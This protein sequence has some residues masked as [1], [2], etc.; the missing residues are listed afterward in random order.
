MGGPIA[1]TFPSDRAAVN[2]FN[3][4]ELLVPAAVLP[5]AASTTPRPAGLGPAQRERQAADSSPG[6]GP[7]LTGVKATMSTR[8]ERP[9]TVD[10]RRRT[11]RKQERI[12]RALLN[13]LNLDR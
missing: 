5:V 2:A 1:H 12:H 11:T 10:V 9:G 8:T 6:S 4:G 3:K 7:A 13:R